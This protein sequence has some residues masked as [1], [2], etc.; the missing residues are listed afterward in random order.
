M[1]VLT[2]KGPVTA[3]VSN[4]RERRLLGQ[5]DT[6]LRTFR[7]RRDGAERALK[8]FEGKTVGGYTLITDT[9]LLIQLDEAGQ[10]DFDTFYASFGA[11]S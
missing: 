10:L 5:Y 7:A 1:T 8:A 2:E 9:K 6:V 3:V 4:S 11:R